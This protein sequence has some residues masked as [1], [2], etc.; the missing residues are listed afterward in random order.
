MKLT[1]YRKIF[2]VL[3]LLVFTGSVSW[4]LSYR[5]IEY[6][7]NSVLKLKNEKLSTLLKTQF[8][9]N[10]LE[11]YR[12]SNLLAFSMND[13]MIFQDSHNS[14]L[15]IQEQVLE[16]D[17]QESADYGACLSKIE[18]LLLFSRNI[19]AEGITTFKKNPT[20]KG[21]LKN[22]QKTADLLK[23]DFETLRSKKQKEFNITIDNIE[24]KSNQ[25]AWMF[26]VGIGV[27]I[28]LIIAFSFAMLRTILVRIKLL[29][30]HFS[31]TSLNSLE[32]IAN[33]GDD[34]LGDLIKTS[35][36]MLMKI[37]N[38]K[39]DLIEKKFVENIINSINDMIIVCKKNGTII[40]ANDQAKKLFIH[41]DK[42]NSVLNIFTHLRNYEPKKI[43]DIGEISAKILNEGHFNTHV[44][45]VHSSSSKETI[46]HFSGTKMTTPNTSEDTLLVITLR[47]ITKEIESEKEKSTLQAQL[48]QSSKLASLGTLGAG[49]AHELNNPL[50]AV[51]GYSELIRNSKDSSERTKDFANTILRCGDRM[52][53]IIEELRKFSENDKMTEFE[54]L[55]IH[56][57]IRSILIFLQ[58]RIKLL[59]IK[60]ELNIRE[61]EN[62]IFGNKKQIEGVFLNLISNS[63]DSFE[64]VKDHREKHIKITVARKNQSVIVYF[65]DNAMGIAKEK[66]KHI[67]DPFFTTKTVGTGTGLGLFVSH[68][69][70]QNHKGNIQ[71]SS[72]Y[73]KGTTFTLNFPAIEK[74]T[75]K[76]NNGE[77]TMSKFKENKKSILIIDDELFILHLFEELL[78][79]N[80]E[81]Y[82]ESNPLE[83][84]HCLTRNHFDLIISDI[85]M[86]QIDG[87]SLVHII[88]EK[89]K[90]RT[91]LILMSG[92]TQS[93][94][95]FEGLKE[96]QD[97]SFLYKPLPKKAELIQIIEGMLLESNSVV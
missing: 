4:Y 28:C 38:S 85:K 93:N 55:P 36:M 81:I 1:I 80:Y 76:N 84:E 71:V 60:I 40:R 86:P 72:T 78:S 39:E 3:S 16:M 46:M 87:Y 51:M 6:S 56:V 67:F 8:L 26:I 19:T 48:A 94:K 22:N 21:L 33:T 30:K 68:Q 44:S 10:E 92:Y 5:F 49:V 74:E 52:K 91:P 34:E 77:P 69:T 32:P 18:S 25:F 7:K 70:V 57:P 73:N 53:N 42:K 23:N 29:S 79:D 20:Y 35:N 88:R 66:M 64:D 95:A 75:L 89:L 59:D 96:D 15:S 97:L 27:L 83:V 90:L 24:A 65:E 61:K 11:H 13:M 12:N 41:N 50:T 63:C 43:I 62:Y 14:L 58:H 47:D 31:E 17:K 45:F 82:T 9:V 54:S 2:I 37:K